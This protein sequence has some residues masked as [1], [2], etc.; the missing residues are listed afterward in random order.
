MTCLWLNAVVRDSKMKPI[1]LCG[2]GI[3]LDSFIDKCY[4]SLDESIGMYFFNETKE[5]EGIPVISHDDHS[6]E[7]DALVMPDSFFCT[8]QPSA[9]RFPEESGQCRTVF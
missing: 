2:T 7:K 9:A 4:E 1:G 5:I 8:G 6:I 3:E